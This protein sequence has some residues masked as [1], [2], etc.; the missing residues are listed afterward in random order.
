MVLV[1]KALVFWGTPT[2]RMEHRILSRGYISRFTQVRVSDACPLGLP[3]IL[4][5]AHVT[6]ALD[7]CSSWN[8]LIQARGA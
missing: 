3:G 6:V 8:L 2:L 1:I 4:T 7:L 5:L